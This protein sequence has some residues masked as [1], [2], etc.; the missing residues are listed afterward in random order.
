MDLVMFLLPWIGS[1]VLVGW[2]GYTT[3]TGFWVTFI[4]SL[5][6]SPLAGIVIVLLSG[7]KDL[8]QDSEDHTSIN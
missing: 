8:K 1:S 3:K 6:F 7:R 5:V 4:L 2:V